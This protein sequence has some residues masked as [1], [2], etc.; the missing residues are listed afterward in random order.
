LVELG[1]ADR[2]TLLSVQEAQFHNNDFRAD[3]FV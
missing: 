1:G 2:I 3:L